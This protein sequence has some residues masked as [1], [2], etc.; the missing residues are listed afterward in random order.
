MANIFLR[1]CVLQIYYLMQ[2]Y[3]CNAWVYVLHEC[4]NLVW[5]HVSCM[6]TCVLYYCVCLKLVHALRMT[7][8]F[9]R[10]TY[11]HSPTL[12]GVFPRELY[13]LP[14]CSYALCRKVITYQNKD[15]Y[16]IILMVRS[17]LVWQTFRLKT[18]KTQT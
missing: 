16:H 7:G 5:V 12:Q 2:E 11:K 17:E 8:I 1:L 10:R 13:L 15:T 18:P 9:L 14:C 3:M 6:G 4:M